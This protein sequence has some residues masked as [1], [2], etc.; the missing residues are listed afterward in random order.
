MATNLKS[1]I[2]DIVETCFT[3]PNSRNTTLLPASILECVL[4][5]LLVV[6]NVA[7]IAYFFRNR[8]SSKTKPQLICM[9]YIMMA[10]SVT[11]IFAQFQKLFLPMW[12]ENSSRFILSTTRAISNIL[13]MEFGFE[14]LVLDSLLQH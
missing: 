12:H 1:G 4:A 7:T 11:N 10:V 2:S 3:L 8:M 6:F 5:A 9:L 14:M 13:F